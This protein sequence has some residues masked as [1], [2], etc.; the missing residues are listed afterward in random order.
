M[1]HFNLFT[2]L[3]W[4]FLISKK[5]VYCYQIARFIQKN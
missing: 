1:C 5:M 4:D 2:K 3:K